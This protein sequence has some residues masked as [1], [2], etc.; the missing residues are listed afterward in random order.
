MLKLLAVIMKVIWMYG[1]VPIEMYELYF[2]LLNWTVRLLHGMKD[3]SVPYEVSVELGR[4]L[5]G[6]NVHVLLR[7][8]ADHRFAQPE[9]IML[10][11]EMLNCMVHGTSE[12]KNLAMQSWD[13]FTHYSHPKAGYLNIGGAR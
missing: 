5:Y 13:S 12:V 3:D 8:K 11:F 6:D 1:V 10:M 9:D 2:A 7:K 4:K